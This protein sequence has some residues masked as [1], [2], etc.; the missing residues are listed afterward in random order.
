MRKTWVNLFIQLNEEL[1]AKWPNITK[2]KE[3][4]PSAD[5]WQNNKNKLLC[6]N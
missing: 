4:L 1:S 5:E 6:S 2:R 3:P